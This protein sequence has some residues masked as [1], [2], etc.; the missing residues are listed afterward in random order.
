[1]AADQFFLNCAVSLAILEALKPYELPELRV[2]W[3]NDI[4]ADNKKL[5]GML[6]E[7]SI[8]SGQIR[9]AIVGIGLNVNEEKFPPELPKAISMYQ[10]LGKKTDRDIL[11]QELVEKINMY[12]ALFESGHYKRLLREYKENLYKFGRPA[13]FETA[14]G[15]I[16]MGKIIDVEPGGSLVLELQDETQRSFRF[17]EIKYL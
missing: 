6:I 1:L 10:I 16:F 17:K 3:P 9:Y 7:N 4:M 5:G 12:A 2:K 11:L 8:L 14:A 13:M 15:E